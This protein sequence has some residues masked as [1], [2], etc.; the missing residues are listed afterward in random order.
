MSLFEQKYRL[1][2]INHKNADDL[3]ELYNQNQSISSILNRVYNTL[4]KLSKESE[5]FNPIDNPLI[6]FYKTISNGN[7][8]IK[9][10]TPQVLSNYLDLGLFIYLLMFVENTI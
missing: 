3:L 2:K 10:H 4:E 7:I 6:G 1:V 8:V 5:S 9:N